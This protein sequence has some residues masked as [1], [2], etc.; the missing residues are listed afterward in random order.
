MGL[1]IPG[2]AVKVTSRVALYLFMIAQRA[3]TQSYW[4][5]YLRA[6]P[7]QYDDP[8][9]WTQDELQL[10]KGTHRLDMYTY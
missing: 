7:Q 8:L 5:P 1:N 9:W 10:L 6:V 2:E 4:G 3:N